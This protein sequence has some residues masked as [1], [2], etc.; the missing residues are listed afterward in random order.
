VINSTKLAHHEPRRKFIL[1]PGEEEFSP[2]LEY[3]QKKLVKL[4]MVKN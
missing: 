3:R 1:M 4:G 2:V